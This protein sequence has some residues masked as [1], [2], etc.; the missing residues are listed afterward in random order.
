MKRLIVSIFVLVFVPYFL[1]GHSKANLL[2]NPDAETGDIQG[3]TDP[4][5][6]WGAAADI[7]PHGGNY[8][9]W[10]VLKET[11]YTHMYQDVDVSSYSGDIDSGKEYFH[12]SGWLANWDQYPH[13]QATLAIEALDNSSQQ[14]LYLSRSHR[15]PVW[16]YYQIESQ[17]PAGTRTLRVNL[18]G[19][20]YM[21]FDNDAY[22]DDLYLG[23]DTVAPTITVEVTSQN[24][25]SKVAIDS[26]LQLLAETTGGVDSGYIWSS[27]FNAVATVDTNGLVTGHTAG[28][29]MIQAEGKN[30]HSAGLF[31]VVVYRT[32]DV[33]F[34]QPENAVQWQGNTNKD[35]TW[36][37]IGSIDSGVLYYTSGSGS[38]WIEIDSISDLSVQQYSWLVPDTNE[39]LNECMLKMTWLGGEA[40]SSVFSIIPGIA[41]EEQSTHQK[42][43]GQAVNSRQLSLTIE[44]NPVRQV[45]VISYQTPDDRLQPLGRKI[46]IYDL[47][48]REIKT[49]RLSQSS[50]FI[51]LDAKDWSAG[52][53]F[54][55]LDTGEQKETRKLVLMSR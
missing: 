14:L 17:V 19:T 1:F 32:N 30:T 12:L 49:F 9:F 6:A 3:W 45:A 23:V 24:G 34:I 51:K 11:T 54:V 29:A 47:S 37:L 39:I 8:F 25:L 46:R 4:D 13:D 52:I 20:R 10:P 27:S 33:I 48:G 36:E 53:Y 2:V 42:D 7:T 40:V 43:G 31:E 5:A 55:H 18:I 50:G 35:I 38:E 16:N 21:G 22:F 15:S 44:Q 41:I 26:V 28:R